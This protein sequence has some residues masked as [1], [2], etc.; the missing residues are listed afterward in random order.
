MN[1]PQATRGAQ[2]IAVFGDKVMFMHTPLK[3]S[4]DKMQ[5]D[6]DTGYFAGINPGTTEYL[7]GKDAGVFT[8]APIRRL[9][10]D[11]AFDPPILEDVKVRYRDYTRERAQLQQRS[12]Q[13]RQV[14][15]CQTLRHRPVYQEGQ[16]LDQRIS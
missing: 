15:R 10:D 16:D 1:L 14:C 4:R 2:P 6:W 9:P 5:S 12:G 13:H 8:C 11:E 7:T 3:S